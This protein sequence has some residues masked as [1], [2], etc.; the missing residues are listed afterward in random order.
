MGKKGTVRD[1]AP[2]K[3]T[4]TSKHGHSVRRVT[5]LEALHELAPV[6]DEFVE[7]SNPPNIFQTF[8]WLLAW[9]EAYGSD[10]SLYVL[11]VESDGQPTGF[12]PLM[13]TEWRG[14]RGQRK[15]IQFIGTPQ[16]D[17]G[18][19]VGPDKKLVIETVLDY[20]RD[21]R[22]DWTEVDLIEIPE[23]SGSVEVLQELLDARSTP[24]LTRIS[25]YCYSFVYEGDNSE[26][27]NFDP[28]K[29]KRLRRSLNWYTRRGNLEL[30]EIRDGDALEK[31]MSGFFHTHIV[32]WRDTFRPSM[33]LERQHRRFYRALARRLA[34]LGR[35]S[36]FVLSFD[37]HP[38]AYEF[39][40]LYCNRSAHYTIAHDKFH[41]HRS[42]GRIINH[43]IRDRYVKDGLEELD[44]SR[45]AHEYKDSLSN[46][47]YANYQVRLFSSRRAYTFARWYQKLKAGS[48]VRA[49]MA[50]KQ[51]SLK[52]QRFDWL[53][54]TYGLRGLALKALLMVARRLVDYR[55]FY[56][57]G[58]SGRPDQ[59]DSDLDLEFARLGEAD[60]DEIASFAGAVAGS[61]HYHDLADRL[62]RADC[63]AARHYSQILSMG[64]GLAFRDTDPVT[65][66]SIEP[67]KGQV[68]LSGGYTSPAARGLGLRPWLMAHQLEFYGSRGLACITVVEKSNEASL[69]VMTKSGFRRI[70]NF[71]QLR[72]FG[73]RIIGPR[74]ARVTF[75]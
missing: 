10:H 19:F 25:E 7:K 1:S 59:P 32:R 17:Y 13:L 18:D 46:R 33:F 45:G 68:I 54:H 4:W 21:H 62:A 48:I 29:S 70:A 9:W 2:D 72:V 47:S 60:L 43:Q 28:R 71:R 23:R 73:R 22:G 16:A 63:F 34:P 52:K 11:A 31:I 5:T 56:V 35:I 39:N 6:W 66:F 50:S 41:H 58:I 51:F 65:G 8:D 55:T 61:P 15:V 12:A 69:R 64:W 38:I 40:F 27:A 74:T 36:F 75:P 3:V 67:R 20:L 53:R 24:H 37:G 14:A 57:F 42:V 30:T 26:R 49:L 44:F